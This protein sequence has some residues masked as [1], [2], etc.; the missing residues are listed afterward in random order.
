MW[1]YIIVLKWVRLL[2]ALL[3]TRQDM[4][5]IHDHFMIYVMLV[6]SPINKSIGGKPNHL[7]FLYHYGLS[8]QQCYN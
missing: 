4:K 1:Y 6:S 2:L 5:L 7:N 3:C 8:F